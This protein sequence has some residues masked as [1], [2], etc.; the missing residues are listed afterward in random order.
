MGWGGP[1]KRAGAPKKGMGGGME[2]R[3]DGREEGW[4]RK[5]NG[6]GVTPRGNLR[7]RM[8]GKEA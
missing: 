4:K 7:R 6:V 1:K 8:R 2:G 3:R 5:G